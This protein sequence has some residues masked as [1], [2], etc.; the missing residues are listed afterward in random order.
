MADVGEHATD[1]GIGGQWTVDTAQSVVIHHNITDSPLTLAESIRDHDSQFSK[2]YQGCIFSGQLDKK[3]QAV[4]K[5]CFCK[6]T[7]HNQS[8]ALRFGTV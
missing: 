3:P 4:G 8:S 2:K 6:K 1:I 5:L 7:S